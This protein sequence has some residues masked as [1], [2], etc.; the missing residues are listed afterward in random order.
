MK[1]G[2]EKWGINII[3]VELE[4]EFGRQA[5]RAQAF[6]WSPELLPPGDTGLVQAVPG[7][8][9]VYV[10][11]ESFDDDDLSDLDDLATV[12]WLLLDTFDINASIPHP[13]TA[14]VEQPGF[15]WC[16]WEVDLDE[17]TY[18]TGPVELDPVTGGLK[19]SIE[20]QDLK[21]DV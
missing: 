15:L 10:S 21:S 13:L 3:E 5:H 7:A 11:P 1:V 14:D 2:S 6:A 12:A 4:D 8:S 17:V 20:L 16:S 18:V 19:L 9:G